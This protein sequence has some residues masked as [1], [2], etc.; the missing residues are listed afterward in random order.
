VGPQISKGDLVDITRYCKRWTYFVL[1]W[2]ILL[3]AALPI[4]ALFSTVVVVGAVLSNTVDGHVWF[5]AFGGVF[6]LIFAIRNWMRAIRELK[7]LNTIRILHFLETR[8]KQRMDMN[9]LREAEAEAL[10]ERRAISDEA[11]N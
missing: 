5:W 2:S 3:A 10:R 6:S 11:L 7:S 4:V 1:P 9:Q 8:K